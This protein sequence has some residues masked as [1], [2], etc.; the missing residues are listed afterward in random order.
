MMLSLVLDFLIALRFPI[1][2]SLAVILLVAVVSQIAVSRLRTILQRGNTAPELQPLILLSVRVVLWVAALLVI[3][4]LFDLTGTLL[5]R[6]ILQPVLNAAVTAVIGIILIKV[7]LKI[8]AR[9]LAHSRLDATTHPFLLTVSRIGLYVLLVL[10]ILP[11]VGVEI[12]PILTA[13]GAVGLAVSLA[14]KDSLANL[15]GGALILI[16]HPFATG[17]FVEIGSLSGTVSEVGPIYTFLN[18][19]DNKRICIPNGQ[20]STS[21][22]VNYSAEPL[23][24]LDLTFSIGYED[25]FQQAKAIIAQTVERHPSALADPA[26]VI[27]M[28]QHGASSI[29]LTCRVWVDNSDY[30][31]LKFDLLEQVKQA[32]D[33]AGINIPYPQMD[34]HLKQS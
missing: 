27:R 28:A 8:L 1:L 18:T 26:P 3:L 13:L 19:P 4:S 32:F 31:N 15:M 24:R 16:S 11:K 21:Q 6:S 14:V 2:A 34:V 25:D 22:V 29:D 7:A 23:R 9:A 20:V 30:W 17:D 5:W 10:V 33:Q 12:T